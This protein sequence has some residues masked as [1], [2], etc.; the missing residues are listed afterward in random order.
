MIRD[1]IIE[2]G[3]VGLYKCLEY[4][5]SIALC[6]CAALWS[7]ISFILILLDSSGNKSWPVWMVL[8][9]SLITL[10]II[11]YRI[12]YTY[13][14]SENDIVSSV[15]LIYKHQAD[16]I[17]HKLKYGLE[18]EHKYPEKNS[19]PIDDLLPNWNKETV[20]QQKFRKIL[21]LSLI[22]ALILIS[23][24]PWKA[25]FSTAFTLNTEDISNNSIVWVSDTTVEVGQPYTLLALVKDTGDISAKLFLNDLKISHLYKNDTLSY[26]IESVNQD[27]HFT[28]RDGD[29]ILSSFQVEVR[30]TLSNTY[31]VLLIPPSYMQQEQVEF[32]NPRKIEAI[33]GSVMRIQEY[34]NEGASILYIKDSIVQFDSDILLMNSSECLAIIQGDTTW[35]MEI[36]VIEDKIPTISIEWD[37]DTTARAYTAIGTF[38]DDYG[39]SSVFRRVNFI[40]SGKVIESKRYN[41]THDKGLEGD[42]ADYFRRKDL[43]KTGIDAIEVSYGVCDNNEV[44]GSQCAYSRKLILTV[45]NQDT[46]DDEKDQEI[47]NMENTAN[48][49]N[50]NQSNMNDRLENIRNERM[51]EAN[52]NADNQEILDFLE[53]LERLNAQKDLLSEELE[54]FMLMSEEFND[55]IDTNILNP[56]IEKYQ[57]GSRREELMDKIRQAL[58]KG[59][60][61]NV[62]DALE[63]LSEME[64]KEE[65]SLEMLERMLSQLMK[66]NALKDAI[67]ALDQLSKEEDALDLN[68]ED[69]LLK[70]EEINEKFNDIKKDIE[71]GKELLGEESEAIEQLSEEIDNDLQDLS[72]E[73]QQGEPSESSKSNT[74]QQMKELSSMLS[75]AMKSAKQKQLEMDLTTLQQLLEN[76]V[77][78][79]FI[80]E[81][82]F[83]SNASSNVGVYTKERKVRN[84]A[85]WN[86]NFDSVKD[87]LMALASRSPAAQ[88]PIIDGILRIE[89][90]QELLEKSFER[91]IQSNWATE[92]QGVMM[93]VNEIALLLDEA[94]QNIQMNLS[95]QMQGSQMCENPGGSGQGQSGKPSKA[96]GLQDIMS[97]QAAMGQQGEKE[98]KSGEGK[99]GNSGEGSS[100]KADEALAALIQEQ[101]KIRNALENWLKANNLEKEGRGVLDQ[102]KRQEQM[103]SEGTTIGTQEYSEGLQNIDLQLLKLEQAANKQGEKETR[104]SSSPLEEDVIIVPEEVQQKISQ[105]LQR[106]KRPQV[107]NP[108]LIAFYDKLWRSFT[109]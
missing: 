62:D 88:K 83:L 51:T 109:Q 54:T 44:K 80:E 58:E 10:F 53:S 76:L 38:Q 20:L 71:E 84:Q 70:Q 16:Q 48:R 5:V 78:L 73:I 55:A 9:F 29:K 2:S 14:R 13:T 97:D 103:L 102:M 41:V 1:K 72:N 28:W 99:Q 23:L 104:K 52:S 81:D 31:K 66:E 26:F 85:L 8:S 42:F 56:L 39:V 33:E 24:S 3:K 59:D 43:W 105:I 61:E 40:R 96:G 34:I 86:K 18:F 67:E 27:L 75:M 82:L 35:T 45:P 17:K 25:A 21:V 57:E 50:N 87:T 37:F 12:L 47:Q 94:L 79:S 19:Q 91:G 100:D 36:D 4:Q 60:Q 89:K 46:W 69:A 98:G 101:A 92:A 65:M 22:T 95:G 32:I 68:Q 6:L 15:L 74:S 63:E 77:D 11:L 106:R 107:E 93:E 7:T 49:L 64:S 108:G 90:R 30:S